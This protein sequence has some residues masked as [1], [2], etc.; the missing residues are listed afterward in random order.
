MAKTIINYVFY[1]FSCRHCAENFNLK[2]QNMGFLPSKPSHSI[3]WLWQIHNMANIKLKGEKTFTIY[4]R[5]AY[6]NDKTYS[7][8]KCL[9]LS[10][11]ELATW[12]FPDDPT[13]DPTHPKIVWPSE[14]NCP[15]CRSDRPDL[16]YSN[17]QIA[18]VHGQLWNLTA[19]VA[20]HHRVYGAD[21]LIA[22]DPSHFQGNPIWIKYHFIHRQ[23]IPH[24][25]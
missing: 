9:N 20:H 16:S 25:K 12:Y 3:L 7:I 13:E 19:L 22:V 21:Q 8:E 5:I 24:D 15:K 10:V 4:G 17:P 2:V 11:F 18:F 14:L 23:I 6:S 1:F